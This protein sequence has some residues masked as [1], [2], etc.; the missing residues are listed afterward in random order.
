[1]MNEKMNFRV[2]P[3]YEGEFA[4]RNQALC[5]FLVQEPVSAEDFAV[6]QRMS[7]ESRFAQ[8][9]AY[10]S[11]FQNPSASSLKS[12]TSYVEK[13]VKSAGAACERE[14]ENQYELRLFAYAVAIRTFPDGAASVNQLA[15]FNLN[16][17]QGIASLKIDSDERIWAMYIFGNTV[18]D[19][20]ST[21]ANRDFHTFLRLMISLATAKEKYSEVD[22]KLPHFSDMGVFVNADQE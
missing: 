1:M 15:P 18:L 2:A 17:L 14:F 21:D 9:L 10:L 7:K 22:A 6:T 20:L 19:Y 16:E 13:V 12:W 5:K 4:R 8:C 11:I 3:D